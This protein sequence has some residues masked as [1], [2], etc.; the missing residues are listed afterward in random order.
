MKL[1]RHEPPPAPPPRYSLEELTESELV[2]IQFALFQ[3]GREGRLP[4]E[5]EARKI[6][7]AITEREWPYS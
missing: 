1:L 4:R 7:S 2:I 6:W 3:L 5:Q